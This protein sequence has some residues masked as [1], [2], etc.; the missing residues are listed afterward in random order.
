MADAA[1]ATVTIPEVTPDTGVRSE[2]ESPQAPAPRGGW[3]PAP[4]DAPRSPLE[5]LRRLATRKSRGGGGGGSRPRRERSGGGRGRIDLRNT[6]QILAGSILIPLGVV[7]ILMAWY[8]AAHTPYVQQQIPYLVSGAFAGLACIFLGGL[9]YWAHWLY[10][11]YDQADLHH[12]EQL[13]V[14]VQT[15]RAMTER[16]GSELPPPPAV[17]GASAAELGRSAPAALAYSPGA[18]YV[19]TQSGSVYHLSDCPVVAHHPEG[20]RTLSAGELGGLDPCRIC[21]G[22][23]R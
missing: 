10:R 20:L 7:F 19:A 14:L 15:L 13:H 4:K 1:W 22:D 23:R 12:E 3:D 8:G 9:L 11:M 17:A 6:W 5:G 16:M 21:C 2:P 18:T